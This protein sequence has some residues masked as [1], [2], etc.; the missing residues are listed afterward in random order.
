[1]P[2]P[3]NLFPTYRKHRATGQAV[4]TIASR[5]HYLGPHGAKASKAEYDRLISEWMVA[6]RPTSISTTAGDP[7]P[8]PLCPACVTGSSRTSTRGTVADAALSR[9]VQR[10]TSKPHFLRGPNHRSII[11]LV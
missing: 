4:V 6:G 3:V 8:A 10:H 2:R 9:R 7:A 1:M 5:D 11:G